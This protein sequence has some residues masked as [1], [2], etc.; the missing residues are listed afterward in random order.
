MIQTLISSLAVVGAF[1]STYFTVVYYRLLPAD[2]KHIP[3]FCRM[4]ETTCRKI[5][6]AREAKA[7]GVPNSIIGLLYYFSILIL[8]MPAFETFFLISSIFAVGLGMYLTHTLLMKLKLHC[9][10]CYMAHL[11]NLVIANLFIVRALQMIL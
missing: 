3:A 8:P 10:L 6:E 1:I 5:L 9:T 4:K 7:L 2:D 11:I